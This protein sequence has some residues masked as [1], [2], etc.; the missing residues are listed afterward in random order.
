[1]KKI[2]FQTLNEFCYA[3]CLYVETRDLCNSF[4][5]QLFLVSKKNIKSIWWMPW[6][7]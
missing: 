2:Q 4:E 1:M 7:Q 6:H 3:Y 5:L